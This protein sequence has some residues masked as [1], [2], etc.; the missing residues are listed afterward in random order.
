MSYANKRERDFQV[1]RRNVYSKISRKVKYDGIEFMSG[2]ALAR[3]LKLPSP[4]TVYA[5]IK[6]GEYKGKKISYL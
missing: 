5:A 6:R 4:T 1:N 2:A 3:Y